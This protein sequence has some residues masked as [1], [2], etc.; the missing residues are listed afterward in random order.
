[1]ARDVVGREHLVPVVGDTAARPPVAPPHH[2]AHRVRVG[3][4]EERLRRRRAPVDE[5]PA[6]RRVREAESSDVHG[7]GVVRSDHAPQAQVEAEAAQQPQ[8]R[9][10]PVDLLVAVQG[11]LA[12]P[13]GLPARGVEA[14]RQVAEGLLE[15]V[16]EG[17]EVPL[18]GADQLRVRLGGEVAGKVEHAG[19]QRVHVISLRPETGGP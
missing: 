9:A 10:E 19:A 15:A 5:Q 6:A 18:V 16:R 7:L 13:A 12:G 1:M 3:R 14:L 2:Q 4:P 17:G 8:P 11:L